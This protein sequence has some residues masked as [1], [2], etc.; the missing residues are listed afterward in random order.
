MKKFVDKFKIPTLLGL[1]I[2]LIGIVTGVYLVL[3]EQTFFSQAAP[4]LTPQNITFTNVTADSIVLSWQTNS[5]AT[6]FVTFGQVNSQEQTALDDRDGSPA[7]AGP[8][9]RLNHYVTIKN[10]LPQTQYQ[11]KIISGKVSSEI[12]KFETAKPATFQAGFT[13]IIGSVLDGDTALNDGIAYVSLSGATSQSALIKTSGSFL[14]PMSQISKSD[15]SGAYQPNEDDIA[16]LTVVSD[17]GQASALF[18]LMSTTQP[19][20]PLKLGQNTDLTAEE[21]PSFSKFD[22]NHDGLINSSDYALALKNKVDLNGDG[23][24]DQKDLELMQKQIN[25]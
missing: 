3:R 4:N 9:P 24:I 21:K 16:K 5:P 19:L 12:L 18:R 17:Q 22:L 7:T 14:I 13:P 23:V 15:L 1:G 20:P 8:Q 6:S 11:F 2:I 25:Q 10:L